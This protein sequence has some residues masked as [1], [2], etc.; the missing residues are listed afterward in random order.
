MQEAALAPVSDCYFSDSGIS[1]LTILRTAA[2]LSYHQ[3][4]L[5]F[6]FNAYI[7]LKNVALMW[8]YTDAEHGVFGN[9]LGLGGQM[10][11]CLSDLQ[12]FEAHDPRDH[13]YAL[14]GVYLR[15]LK[16]S[17][18]PHLLQPDY[19][20]PV[21]E[22]LRD[23]AIY[24]FAE[25]ETLRCFKQLEL[26][27]GKQ[28]GRDD[29]PSWVPCWGQSWAP[30]HGHERVAPFRSDFQASGKYTKTAVGEQVLSATWHDLNVLYVRGCVAGGLTKTWPGLGLEWNLADRLETLTSVEQ[31]LKRAGHGVNEIFE[32]IATT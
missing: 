27:S 28:R 21:S 5:P 7:G 31:E 8:A 3:Q 14:L 15:P 12:D 2:W 18:I 1:L 19:G 20:R 26:P 13:V 29:T 9:S 22:V 24:T 32:M 17:R 16:T 25:D 11:Q 23:A 4:N 6:A 30:G 10:S